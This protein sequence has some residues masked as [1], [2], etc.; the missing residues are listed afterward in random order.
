V[1]DD[2]F[3]GQHEADRFIDYALP[4]AAVRLYPALLA[5]EQADTLMAQLLADIA[6]QR[7]KITVYGKEYAVPRLTAWHGDPQLQ[8]AYSG[9]SAVTKPWTESLLVIKRRIEEVTDARFNS[10][11]LN[12]YRTGAD[13]M[14]WHSDNEPE[15]GRNP[16]IASVTLGQSRPFHLK[17]KTLTGVRQS[18]RLEHGSLLLMSGETQHHWLHQ[19]P[20][21]QRTMG[22]RVN[23]TFRIIK[24]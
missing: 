16:V 11:L 1:T 6:W 14:G 21:S 2:L 15:L 20:K 18:L 8:Y 3:S 13:S 17:H 23:L 24:S 9:I 7:D 19:V 10:V 22:E 5:L 12:R 4:D